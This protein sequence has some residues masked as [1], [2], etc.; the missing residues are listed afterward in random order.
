MFNLKKQEGKCTS[1]FKSI[2]A[3]ARTRVPYILFYFALP[4]SHNGSPQMY[5]LA[6]LELLGEEIS[7]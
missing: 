1:F 2:R 5:V 7:N 6:C 4:L 3:G